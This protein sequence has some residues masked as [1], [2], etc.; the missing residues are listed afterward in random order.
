MLGDASGLRS[1]LVGLGLLAVRRVRYRAVTGGARQTL[2]SIIGVALAVG[3]VLSVT[4]IG[5]GLAAQ[6]TVQTSTTDYRIVPADSQGSAVIGVSGTRFGRVH[7]VATRLERR[8]GV[9]AVTPLLVDL[10]RVQPA[11][12]EQAQRVFVIGVVPQPDGGQ[13][14]GLPTGALQPGDPYYANGSYNGSWTG[15]AVVSASAAD[16]LNVSTGERLHVPGQQSGAG[17]LSVVAIRPAQ[18]PGLAQFPVVVVHLAE[19]QQFAGATH[20][21]EADQFHVATT[22]PEAKAALTGVYPQS[23]VVSRQEM[24]THALRSSEL[25]LAMSLAA[26]IIAVVVGVLT[27]VTTLGFELAG[28]AESRAVLAAMGVSR[29]L[30]LGLVVVETLVTTLAGGLVGVGLWLVGVTLINV[31]GHHVVQVPL[32]VVGPL[33]GV[34]GVGIAL[35]VGL[36]ALPFLL[37][38]TRRTTLLEA[39]PT[40]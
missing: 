33:L 15:E 8:E 28:D 25:P 5:L 6:D 38:F 3:L 7:S 40:Q 16:T 11:D 17:P 12:A 2:L 29:R 4:S 31:V 30:R 27:V 13:I 14:A 22:R 1:F 34:Y 35:G 20:G 19:A 9:A 21:D 37:L 18:A 39:L 10:V 26:G 23:K 36:A 32:A 24:V